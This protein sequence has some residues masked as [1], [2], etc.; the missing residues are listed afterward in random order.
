MASF[1]KNL[2][3]IFFNIWSVLVIKK[4]C[5]PTLFLL[6]ISCAAFLHLC[7]EGLL[8]NTV[9]CMTNESGGVPHFQVKQGST[10]VIDCKELY[11]RFP[12]LA[13]SKSFITN[14][15]PLNDGSGLYEKFVKADKSILDTSQMSYKDY[16]SLKA[17][18]SQPK[19][20]RSLGSFINSVVKTTK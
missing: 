17:A 1:I 14:P 20:M 6:T 15:I 19:C 4:W 7:G 2:D 8:L 12:E 18:S 9:Y 3:Q 5:F 13:G 11:A 16:Y 10:T